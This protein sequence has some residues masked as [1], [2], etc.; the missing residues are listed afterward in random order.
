MGS[1]QQ[2]LGSGISIRKGKVYQFVGE[3]YQ[4]VKMGNEYHG[5][6]E[7]Y[8]LE[9]RKREMG[10]G[11]LTKNEDL[12]NKDWEE[13]QVVGNFIPGMRIRIRIRALGP[14]L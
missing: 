3:E 1:K 2:S 4:F 9:K 7:E 8:N 14:T 13:Y 5:C 6:G 12:K 10:T 11:N